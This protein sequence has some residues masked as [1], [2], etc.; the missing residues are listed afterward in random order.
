MRCI[1]CDSL[2]LT[3][4]GVR[5]SWMQC[6]CAISC[7]ILLPYHGCA[8]NVLWWSINWR[9]GRSNLYC[10]LF[11]CFW[12]GRDINTKH[13]KGIVVFGEDKWQGGTI[14]FKHVYTYEQ[15]AFFFQKVFFF[16]L[17]FTFQLIFF[18]FFVL[19]SS[20][21]IILGSLVRGVYPQGPCGQA[22]VTVVFLPP[23]PSPHSYANYVTKT[24]AVVL[25][26]VD[27][28][29]FVLILVSVHAMPMFVFR[30]IGWY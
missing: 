6:A 5:I 23:P 15:Y 16:H 21:R 4:I 25:F 18:F 24:L 27:R 17:F 19:F 22:A 30:S 28:V 12:W 26:F 14:P 8:V 9:F 3:C 10:T 11:E 13:H 1:N 20:I 2:A 29:G 7:N